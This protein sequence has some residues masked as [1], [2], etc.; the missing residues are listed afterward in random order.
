MIGCFRLV[1]L[2]RSQQHVSLDPRGLRQASH[3]HRPDDGEGFVK[4]A[5]AEE[6]PG[7]D[8]HGMRTVR[9]LGFDLRGLILG[10]VPFA[11]LEKH[12]PE[13]D[14]DRERIRRDPLG[15]GQLPPGVE[16]PG[17]FRVGFSES[18][19]GR[20]ELGVNLQGDPYLDDRFVDLVLF[21][22][23]LPALESLFLLHFGAL[24]ARSGSQQRHQGEEH[25]HREPGALPGRPT[26][27]ERRRPGADHRE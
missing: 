17:L 3:R 16:I 26:L 24:R 19:Q 6:D 9:I 2:P 5:P 23:P 1:E 8:R 7:P 20:C 18:A 11:E 25:R 13:S 12:V 27:K 21:E 15:P 4:L 22:V 10:F 14:A